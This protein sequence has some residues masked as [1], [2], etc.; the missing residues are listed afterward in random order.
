M[1]ASRASGDM[2]VSENSRWNPGAVNTGRQCA[3]SL[4]PTSPMT[5]ARATAPSVNS[6]GKPD[7]EAP[8]TRSPSAVT[9]TVR[10]ESG[11]SVHEVARVT[12][13]WPGLPSTS[14][15][16]SARA[17]GTESMRTRR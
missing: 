5:R 14:E 9:A 17:A 11:L 4:G 8:S 10:Q 7:S 13:G 1:A 2:A 12:C 3:G 15:P 16:S 6:A